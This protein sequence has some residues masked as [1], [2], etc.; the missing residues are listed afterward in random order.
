[1]EWFKPGDPIVE[2][3][4]FGVSSMAMAIKGG[5]GKLRLLFQ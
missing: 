5:A 3:V 2:E 4:L 1:M